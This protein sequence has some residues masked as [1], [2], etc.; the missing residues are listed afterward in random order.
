MVSVIVGISYLPFFLPADFL[1][2]D[3]L[4]AF[5][6]G[7]DALAS[8]LCVAALRADFFAAFASAFASAFAARSDL[9]FAASRFPLPASRFS[10]TDSSAYPSAFDS[11]STT[12]D[13]RM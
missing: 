11:I 1:A 7:F 6:F 12:S 4:A 10:S 8:A 5:A 9:A 3:F 2:D 13:Q